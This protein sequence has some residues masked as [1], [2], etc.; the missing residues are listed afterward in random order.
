M[1][2]LYYGISIPEDSDYGKE[3]V[4][5]RK[6]YTDKSEVMKILKDIRRAAA[7]ILPQNEPT[8]SFFLP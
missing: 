4:L 5:L 1:V 3:N 6:Y 2:D 7:R 8:S